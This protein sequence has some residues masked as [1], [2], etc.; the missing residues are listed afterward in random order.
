MD[1][2]PTH[3]PTPPTLDSRIPTGPIEDRWDNHRFDVKLVN[4]ANKRKY[5]IIVI[6]T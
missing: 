2:E 3:S 1:M 5:D 4:P 6:G